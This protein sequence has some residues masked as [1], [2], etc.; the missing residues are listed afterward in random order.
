MAS[1]KKSTA[2]LAVAQTPD[3]AQQTD[4]EQLRSDLAKLRESAVEVA[5]SC[6]AFRRV[7]DAQGLPE[8]LADAETIEFERQDGLID[9]F[10]GVDRR[11]MRIVLTDGGLAQQAVER[12]AA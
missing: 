5:F 11:T 8:V 3:P 7:E 2:K 9:H 10:K 6:T 12:D 1:S 4:K